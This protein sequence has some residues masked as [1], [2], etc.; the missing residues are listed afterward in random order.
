MVTLSYFLVLS[1]MIG[2]VSLIDY[3][4]LHKSLSEMFFFILAMYG[5]T[6]RVWI[7]LALIIG[8]VFSII[9]DIM[10]HKK[11]KSKGLSNG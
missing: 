9:T 11:K 6:Q 10:E 8:F 5:G 2:G 4:L 1:L 7:V 3:Y